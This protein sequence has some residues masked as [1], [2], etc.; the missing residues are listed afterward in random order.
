MLALTALTHDEN[1]NIKLHYSNKNDSVV[2]P[3]ISVISVG[4]GTGGGGGGEVGSS[5]AS[6]QS[7][8]KMKIP[9]QQ[10]QKLRF[11]F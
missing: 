9:Q 11:I 1:D 10:V 7:V 5:G 8:L 4:E 3:L 6:L 2:S